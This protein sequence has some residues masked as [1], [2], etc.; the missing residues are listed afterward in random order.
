MYLCFL[1]SLFKA[2]VH[3]KLLGYS[4]ALKMSISSVRANLDLAYSYR[5]YN[6]WESRTI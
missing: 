6:G 3:P 4:F 5:Q 1:N 2:F